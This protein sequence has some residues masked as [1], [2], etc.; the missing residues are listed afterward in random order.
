MKEAD[1]VIIGGGPAGIAAAIEAAGR[2]VSVVIIDENRSLG[3]KVLSSGEGGLQIDHTDKIEERIGFQLLNEFNQVEDKV[4]VYL[5]TEVWQVDDQ[6]TVYL[7][8]ENKS[9]R[10]QKR[11]RSQKLIMATGALERIIPFPGWTLPGVF[12]VGG[13]NSLIKKKVIPGQKFLIAGSG[14]LQL[15]LAQN[16]IKA[17]ASI[18]AFVEAS[19]IR[20]VVAKSVQLLTGAG[21][22]RLRQGLNYLLKIKSVGIPLFSSCIVSRA[23]GDKK[24]N[25]AIITKVDANWRPIQ[26]TEKEIEADVI[27]VGYG[28]IPSNEL[29]RQCGCRHVYDDQL[30]YWRVIRNDRMETTIPG[31]FVAG[32]EIQIKG[33][34]AAIDEGRQAGIEA[35]A[36]LGRIQR[37]QAKQHTPTLQKKLNR[38]IRFGRAIDMISAP[39]PGIFDNISD[40][41]T[42]CRCE[43]VTFADIKKSISNGA[44]DVNDIKRRTRLGMGHCQ[45]RFCGQVIN[46]LLWNLSGKT[47]EREYFTPRIPVKP[48][49]FR[50]LAG[51]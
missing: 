38:A 8:T 43:E 36:Q 47:S 37:D 28:L 50:T 33:Y 20:D 13:L 10:P 1:L 40:D 2:G 42:I 9:I 15:A 21:L 48:V 31:V 24:A 46:E 16:L 27:A 14:L 22:L 25:K 4:T 39:R 17:G 29:T 32:D 41:T 18:S 51:D 5:R 45:G 12:P 7:N 44:A 35:C 19:T 30:G 49:P 11:I 34:Q 3:G 23:M 26:G 6:K